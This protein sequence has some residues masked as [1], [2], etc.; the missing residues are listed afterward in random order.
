M[1][2]KRFTM[3]TI[4]RIWNDGD[5]DCTEIGPDADGTGMIELRYRD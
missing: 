2:D 4:R 3:E 1:N 5:G